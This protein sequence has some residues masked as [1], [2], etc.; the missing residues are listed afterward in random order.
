[1]AL[2]EDI[3]QAEGENSRTKVLAAVRR[4]SKEN[5]KYVSNLNK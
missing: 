5:C 1:M 2:F 4:P 3:S